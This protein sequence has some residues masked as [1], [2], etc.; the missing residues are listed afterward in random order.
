MTGVPNSNIEVLWAKLSVGKCRSMLFASVYRV[1]TNT[2]AQVTADLEDLEC[3]V[4]HMLAN[5]PGATFV[6]AGDLNCCLLKCAANSPG[7]RLSRLLTT[8]GLSICNAD[9][10]TY[11]PAESCKGTPQVL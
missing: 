1:P 11:R 6:I 2:S 9:R 8:Y 3:Q 10:P 5:C 4:Q 7:E